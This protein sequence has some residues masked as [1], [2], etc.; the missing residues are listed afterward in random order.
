LIQDWYPVQAIH[1]RENCYRIVEINP[2]P[3]H[4]YLQI[5]FTAAKCGT[6]KK[7]DNADQ[8]INPIDDR[9]DLTFFRQRLSIVADPNAYFVLFVRDIFSNQSLF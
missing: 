5:S 9:A 8:N 6:S 3:E 7:A 2:D 4:F 1:E